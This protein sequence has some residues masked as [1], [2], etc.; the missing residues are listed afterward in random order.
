MK[1][2]IVSLKGIEPPFS[3]PETDVLSIELQGHS[4]FYHLFG[5]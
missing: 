1:G 3:V 4:L 5:F 2:E